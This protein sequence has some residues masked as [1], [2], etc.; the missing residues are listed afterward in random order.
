MLEGVSSTQ[1]TRVL[2][3]YIVN[4][5]KIERAK[6]TTVAAAPAPGTCP[7]LGVVEEMRVWSKS[8]QAS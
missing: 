8:L 5:I 1:K 6:G 4:G 7:W 2:F 3:W